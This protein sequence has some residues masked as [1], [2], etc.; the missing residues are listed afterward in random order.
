MTTARVEPKTASNTTPNRQQAIAAR[1]E[2]MPP[3]CRRTYQRAVNG[4][5]AAAIKAQCLECVGWV[6]AEVTG[7]TDVGCPLYA[8]RPFRK[9]S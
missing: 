7:C 8:V 5:K 3:K 1:L 9:R 4:S 6:R 2:Q